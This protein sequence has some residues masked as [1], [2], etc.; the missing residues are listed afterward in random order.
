MRKHVQRIAILLF[1]ML[2]HFSLLDAASNPLFYL[3]THDVQVVV[4]ETGELL[5]TETLIYAFSGR[6]SA[7]LMRRIPLDHVDRIMD[8]QV[9]KD[10]HRL[11]VKTSDN[12]K[13]YV[14]RWY[15]QPRTAGLQTFI[16]QYRAEGALRVD[17]RHDQVVWP[18]LFGTRDVAIQ[19]GRV[20]V[21]L[22]ASLSG[23]IQRFTSYGVPSRAWQ[24]DDRTV[25]FEPRRKPHAHEDLTVKLYVPHGRLKTSAP[26]WQRGE[27]AAYRLPGMLGYVDT[28]VFVVCGIGLF[29]SWVAAAAQKHQWEMERASRSGEVM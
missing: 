9:F 4:E 5:V 29:A 24:V 15:H 17:N 18:A 26:A 14:I 19:S 7:K 8:I 27:E 13:Q 6:Q 10:G 21:R 20:T 2:S 23:Q 3:Q 12:G 25:T 11:P 16:L 28:L 1:L 22:P